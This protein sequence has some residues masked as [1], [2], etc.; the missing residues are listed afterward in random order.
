MTSRSISRW[1]GPCCSA[2]SWVSFAWNDSWPH[3][4]R[5]QWASIAVNTARSRWA[6]SSACR[7]LPSRATPCG[8]KHYPWTGRIT[9]PSASWIVRPEIS[10][11][12]RHW[13]LGYLSSYAQHLFRLRWLRWHTHN[14][15][16]SQPR[17]P[18][19]YGP[20]SRSHALRRFTWWTSSHP[21]RWSSCW[22]VW[23]SW[24]LIYMLLLTVDTWPYLSPVEACICEPSY[25]WYHACD[26]GD[27]I[28]SHLFFCL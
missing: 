3:W 13:L 7:M 10:R 28:V 20:S 26:I 21:S 5:V 17:R 27:L 1:L 15:C 18:R 14:P 4:M 24:H 25:A 19:L 12:S 22:T 11:T 16:R 2:S 9:F 6:W 23:L 8:R